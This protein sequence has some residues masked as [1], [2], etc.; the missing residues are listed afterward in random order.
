[1]KKFYVIKCPK[2]GYEY[3]PEEIYVK[4]LGTSKNVVR[5]EN[6][7]IMFF[8]GESLNLHEEYICDNCGCTFDVDVKPTFET[9][10]NVKHDFS[11]DFTTPIY[12]EERIELKEPKEDKGLW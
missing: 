8:E 7:K 3:L 4:V 5:D 12:E 2:C 9:K 10:V 6:G 1:M 11:E